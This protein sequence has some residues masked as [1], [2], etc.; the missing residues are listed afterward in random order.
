MRYLRQHMKLVRARYV[1]AHRYF[2]ARNRAAATHRLL[3]RWN[4]AYRF[5]VRKHNKAIKAHKWAYKMMKKA[6]HAK[7]RAM[8][9][10]K[11]TAA[12]L[13]SARKNEARKH[14][15]YRYWNAKWNASRRSVKKAVHWMRVCAHRRA[16]ALKN[17]RVAHHKRVHA[18]RINRSAYARMRR[19]IRIHAVRRSHEHKARHSRNVAAHRRKVALARLRR[20]H[21]NHRSAINRKRA[22]YRAAIRAHHA[23]IRHMRKN[24]HHL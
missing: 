6:L 14:K 24:M 22:A 20:A 17:Y 8:H 11:I 4:R 10:H 16:A 5:E 23:V 19:A 21:K 15:S 12:R 3:L 18:G 1:R 9:Y 13:R 7:M 2:N